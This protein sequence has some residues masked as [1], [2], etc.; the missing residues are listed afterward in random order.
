MKT[1]VYLANEF[2]NPVEWYV[3]E[4]I[5][6][7]RRRG[8]RVVPHSSKRVANGN[9]PADVADLAAET[10]CLLPL[11]VQDVLGTILLF[12]LRARDLADFFRRIL[13][14][15]HEAWHLRFRAI[16]HTLLGVTM[17][18]RLRRTN[19]S[20]VH[21]HHGYFSSWIAMVAAHLLRVPFSMTLHGSDLLLHGVYLDLKL[22]RCDFCLTVSEFNRRHILAHFPQVAAH[23]VLLQRLGVRRHDVTVTPMQEFSDGQPVTL[24]SVGRLQ[25][26]KNHV[27]LIQA[28]F[29]L[30]EYGVPIRC[31][32]AGE[33]P[34]RRRLELLIRELG[35]DEQVRLLGQVPRRE[36]ARYYDLADLVVLTSHS[37]GIPIVLMEAM[38]RGRVVIAPAITGIPELVIDGRTGFLYK[39]GALEEFVW[40]VDRIRR[41]LPEMSVVRRAARD[42]VR[43]QFDLEKNLG[44]LGDLFVQRVADTSEEIYENPVLQQI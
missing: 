16:A 5:R 3:V 44:A 6:E 33:G 4:E 14:E 43:D 10:T 29:F 39:P 35:L 15:G 18:H 2:P 22:E 24:L 41:V 8:L 7:L 27:F 20:H 37:E 19:A 17:A 38:A 40:L 13:L 21:V 1:V 23:K 34:E 31:L 25:P 30:R 26:V 11:S 42:R 32:I 28:C 9:V 36:L 12:V